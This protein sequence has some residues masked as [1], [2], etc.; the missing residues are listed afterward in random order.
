MSKH[1]GDSGKEKI[2]EEA[3]SS[4]RTVS[5]KSEQLVFPVSGWL[6]KLLKSRAS[7][8][9]QQEAKETKTS[10]SSVSSVSTPPSSA[11]SFCSLS[12]S[13][14]GTTPSKILKPQSALS[15]LLRWNRNYDVFVCHSSVDSD[16]EEALRLV[17]FLEASPRSLRCFLRQRDDCPGGAISTELCQAVQNSHLWAL[18]ITPDFLQDEWCKYMMHQALA[19]GPMSNRIIPLVQNLS[20]SQFPQELKF[21]FYIDLSRNPDRGYTLLNKA[22]LKYLEDLVRN[23]KTLD[24]NV[25]SSSNGLSGE[26]SSK[27]D[28]PTVTSIPLEVIKKRGESFCNVC[29]DHQQ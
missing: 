11:L 17:S 13:S 2:F 28:D 6:Q 14:P 18:L 20:R 8:S 16:M 19:E 7:L 5:Q 27:K 15:S 24:C 25:D 22:V 3:E 1:F 9:A 26:D 23:E 21:F 12:S 10:V 4:S 29:Y